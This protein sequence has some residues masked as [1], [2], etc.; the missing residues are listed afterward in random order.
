M[1]DVA[2]CSSPASATHLG[3]P[4]ESPAYPA[5]DKAPRLPSEL[6]EMVLARAGALT[7]LPSQQDVA[8][9]ASAA[10]QLPL[11][12]AA[13]QL[14]AAIQQMTAQWGAP[15]E[16][17]DGMPSS[18]LKEEI[19]L[20]AAAT[21]ALALAKVRNAAAAKSGV[22]AAA[23]A[24]LVPIAS[25]G[26]AKR[27]V[28]AR[29]HKAAVA[30]SDVLMRSLQG[31]VRDVERQLGY[32]D[33]PTAADVQP[34]MPVLFEQLSAEGIA[35]WACALSV[36]A[37]KGE[38]GG[39]MSRHLSRR[40]AALLF[41]DPLLPPHPI[42]LAI[43][44]A[45]SAVFLPVL[46]EM[47]QVGMFRGEGRLL[48][49]RLVELAQRSMLRQGFRLPPG[50]SCGQILGLL[51]CAVTAAPASSLSVSPLCQPSAQ[52]LLALLPWARLDAADGVPGALQAA[53][54]LQVS[55][56]NA[57]GSLALVCDV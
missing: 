11:A 35:A 2:S 38:Q 29:G 8:A 30:L 36:A 17:Q 39:L 46:P 55:A 23:A 19:D 42:N 53:L 44:A 24:C 47:G 6:L 13:D 45:A 1:L 57:C 9:Q 51:D 37:T 48:A 28:Q 33:G 32:A 18:Q 52:A 49:C 14:Q 3:D 5:S 12:L 16:C 40:A 21:L 56:K 27:S 34:Q 26:S 22:L 31:F 15:A 4:Q 43:T 20:N 7:S 10:T 25:A 54:L 41:R 50:L